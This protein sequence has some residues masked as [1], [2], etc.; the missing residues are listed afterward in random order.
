MLLHG[1]IVA[2]HRKGHGPTIAR[3]QETFGVQRAGHFGVTGQPERTVRA[4]KRADQGA[5]ILREG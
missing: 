3:D 1:E 2:L 5:Q 4:G